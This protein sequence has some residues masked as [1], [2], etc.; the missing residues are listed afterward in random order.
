MAAAFSKVA[1]INLPP[2][3]SFATFL[4]QTMVGG[5][6]SVIG[7]GKFGNGAL[8]A[9]MGYLFNALSAMTRGT[10]YHAA[11]VTELQ[12]R[13]PGRQIVGEYSF[14]KG[15]ADL[16]IDGH[17]IIELKPESYLD[18]PG[19]YADAKAQVNGYVGKLNA[20]FQSQGLP[21]VA[22]TGSFSDLDPNING[23]AFNVIDIRRGENVYIGGALYYNDPRGH[24]G[25]VFYQ[26]HENLR[27]GDRFI[28]WNTKK[29]GGCR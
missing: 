7:G 22:R 17:I 18:D 6:A 11:L 13:F 19:K 9:S 28:C 27:I 2:T 15:R 23:L 16:V 20:E 12:K 29:E 25:L 4:I 26:H 14:W 24:S 1:T 5:T 10:A 21:S 3:P 8:T